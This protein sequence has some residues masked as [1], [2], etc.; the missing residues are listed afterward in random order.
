MLKNITISA[1]VKVYW[2]WINTNLYPRI[3]SKWWVTSNEQYWF[4]FNYVPVVI[5]WYDYVWLESRLDPGYYKTSTLTGYTINISYLEKKWHHVAWSYD[6]NTIKYYFDWEKVWEDNTTFNWD[7]VSSTKH[8]IIWNA[9]WDAWYNR[10]V[11]GLIN[12]MYIYNRAL[13]KKE[14][15]ILSSKFIR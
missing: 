9:W 3:F 12:Q 14:I 13:S 7:I 6:W 2:V 8:F 11:Y 15:K 10:A 1:Y 4:W 5:S